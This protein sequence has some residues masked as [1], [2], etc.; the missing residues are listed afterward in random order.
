[1]C[2]RVV[3]NAK[4]ENIARCGESIKESEEKMA[5]IVKNAKGF[6]V[7]QIKAVELMEII[8]QSIGMCDYC[9]QASLDGYYIAVLNAYYCPACYNNWCK[10][11]E[12][13][14]ED[15]PY[16]EKSFNRTVA[17]LKEKN[18]LEEETE[19]AKIQ[20]QTH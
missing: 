6:K 7:I 17:L 5:K 15:R 14:E 1:M 8:P 12:Y 11:A 13:Y 20:S 10:R 16:E 3:K 2:Q 9:G 4:Q 18:L 19:D